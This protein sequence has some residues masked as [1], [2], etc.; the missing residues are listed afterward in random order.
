MKV[1]DAISEFGNFE[2]RQ[3]RAMNKPYCLGTSARTVAVEFWVITLPSKS[4]TAVS[5]IVGGVS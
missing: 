5:E 2:Q 3:I 4:S 1:L